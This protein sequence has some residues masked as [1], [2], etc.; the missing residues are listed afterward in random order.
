MSH[1]DNSRLLECS[2]GAESLFKLFDMFITSMYELTLEHLNKL[3][4]KLVSMSVTDREME[5]TM[6]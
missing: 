4:K 3:D 2:F 1:V 6:I 5:R